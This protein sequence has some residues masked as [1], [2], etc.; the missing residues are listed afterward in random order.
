M[1]CRN[2]LLVF[3][4][5]LG[6]LSSQAQSNLLNAK[7]PA[8]IGKKTAAQLI[9]DNDNHYLMVTFMIEIYYSVKQHGNLLT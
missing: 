7:T 9:S 1:N 8:D 3:V 5:T 6:C 2:F 4:L